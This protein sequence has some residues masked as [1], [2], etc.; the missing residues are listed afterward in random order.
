MIITMNDGTYYV[1]KPK[2]GIIIT[3]DM[4]S[5]MAVQ[6]VDPRI[7]GA[8]KVHDFLTAREQVRVEPTRGILKITP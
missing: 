2:T 5:F 6:H 8:E 7:E 4:L 1:T 3:N